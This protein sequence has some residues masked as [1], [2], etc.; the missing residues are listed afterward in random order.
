MNT[1][2]ING[3]QIEKFNVHN[4]PVG[5]QDSI[6]PLCS[7]ERSSKNTKAK[8]ASLDWNRGIGTCH[9][10]NNTFQL[11]TFS[12][13]GGIEYS[14]PKANEKTEIDS[15]V[16]DW[17]NNRGIS[18]PTLGLGKVTTSPGW[19]EFNFYKYGELVN[20]KSR[21]AKKQFR[22]EKNCE[23]V[24]YNHDALFNHDSIIIVEGE[25][26]ALSYMEAGHLNV[27]SV[28]NGATNF[29]YLDSSIDLFDHIDKV[30]LSIDQ[31][32]AGDKLKNELV[33][34][35]G[36][37]KSYIVTLPGAKDANEFLVDNGSDALSNCLANAEQVPLEN[38]NTLTNISGD[39]KEY[40]FEG[41]KPGFQ[42]GANN[43]DSVFS[44]YTSQFVV[45][46]GIPGAGKSDWIDMMTMGYQKKYGWKTAY[47][48]PENKP[49]YIH[50]S[51]IFRKYWDGHPKKEDVG[52]EKWN[53]IH[54]VVDD[55]FFFID[56]DHFQL[57]SVLKKASE[58]VK[59]KGI[60]CLVIDPYNKV[61]LKKGS[62]MSVTDYT[63]EYLTQ[64]DLWAKK[65]D[66]LVILAAHPVKMQRKEDGEFEEPTF[67]SI[68][69]GGEWY[70]MSY[71][72]LCVHRNYSE[73]WTKVKVLK[74]KF[75]NL[76]TNGAETYFTWDKAS[77]KFIERQEISSKLPWESVEEATASAPPKGLLTDDVPF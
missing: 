50:A 74:C 64:I 22:L 18:A 47:A 24:W 59:R 4:L 5:K 29:S 73:N 77:G 37:E 13:K 38:V 56:M 49:D 26:D 54:Q 1:T 76:G 32:E 7:E 45:V 6:C 2:E 36:A 48:S 58:L 16:I 69:G 19:I 70:D 10:C 23:V 67:Y 27:V 72:G 20:R 30:Y 42:I 41:A 3:F 14:K 9:H 62:G 68:K 17:F 55:N 34:R 65:H 66:C 21:N 12:K 35:L 44:T 8:C 53:Q 71:H 61:R 31:D 51:K 33:R 43:F 46:T 28:P 39:L 60:R 63:M 57:E 52:G 25:I 75:Q 40:F 11:H 15:R